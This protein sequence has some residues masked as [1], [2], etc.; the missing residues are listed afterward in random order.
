MRQAFIK[1]LAH[2]EA[3]ID[4]EADETADARLSDSFKQVLHDAEELAL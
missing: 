4:F 3:F 1:M 2:T